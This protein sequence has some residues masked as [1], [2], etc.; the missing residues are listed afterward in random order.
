MEKQGMIETILYQ[1]NE[2]LKLNQYYNR[3]IQQETIA[4]KAEEKINKL[5]KISQASKKQIIGVVESTLKKLKEKMRS[6]LIIIILK[7]IFKRILKT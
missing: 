2:L 7:I 4:R 5:N 1:D 6:K 3:D